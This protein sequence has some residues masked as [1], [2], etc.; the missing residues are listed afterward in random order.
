MLSEDE[1]DSGDFLPFFY[2]SIF[3][4]VHNTF[5]SQENNN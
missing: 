5:Y 4:R 1:S 2:L 3:Y